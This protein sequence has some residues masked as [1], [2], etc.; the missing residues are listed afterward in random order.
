MPS[1]TLSQRLSEGRIPVAD[2]LRYAMIL[3]DALRKIH[4]DGRAHGA[5]SPD[6]IGLTASGLELLQAPAL[7]SAASYMSPE[8]L[9]GR[10]ADSRSDIFSF[11]AVIYEMLSGRKAFEG[12]DRR[13]MASSGSPALDRLVGGCVAKEPAARIQRIQKVMLELKLLAVSA[14]RSAAQAVPRRDPAAEL[15]QMEDRLRAEL[16]QIEERI[17]ARLEAALGR[18]QQLEQAEPVAAPDTAPLESAMEGIRHQVSELHQMVGQDFLNFEKVLQ[19]QATAIDSARTAI[20]QT[21]D[22]VERVVEA[23]ESLQ[24]TVLENS[25]DRALSMN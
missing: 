15:Q 24:A 12:T 23:L 9:E 3:A 21:D 1:Q 16:R 2:A 13:A 4:D 20:A 6:T 22:L 11:G 18:I 5:V 7:D 25:E 17:T 10:P 19:S 8:V 14:S